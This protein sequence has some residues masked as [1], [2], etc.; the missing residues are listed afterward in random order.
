MSRPVG[1]FTEPETRWEAFI[2]GKQGQESRN[3]GIW[4]DSGARLGMDTAIGKAIHSAVT[5]ALAGGKLGMTVN[6]TINA[7]PGSD[8]RLLARRIM[9]EIAREL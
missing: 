2:S 9:R 1:A 5:D 3:R 7:A 6:Q 4:L 8:E